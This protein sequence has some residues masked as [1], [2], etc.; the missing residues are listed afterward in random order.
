MYSVT[1]YVN[2]FLKFRESEAIE[3]PGFNIDANQKGVVEEKKK[4]N[5][6]PAL[7]LGNVGLV[8]SL[9][10]AGIPVYVGSEARKNPCFY[11]RYVKGKVQFSTYR[12]QTFID[13]LCEFGKTLDQKAVIFSDD[14]DALLT[15]SNHRDQLS[16]YF[17]FLFPPKETV[18]KVLDKQEFS[19]LSKIH[20]LPAPASFNI[21]SFDE[22]KKSAKQCTFP[23]IIKPVFRSDWYREDFEKIVG[24]YKKAYK[25]LDEEE[26]F[27]MYKKVS[28]I[29]KKVVLQEYIEGDDTYHY[30]V[31]M[32]V[33]KDEEVR[34]YYIAKKLRIYPIGAGMG[35]F[36][37][38]V[39]DEVV[40][41][42]AVEVVKALNLRGLLNIQF[43]RDSRTGEPKLIEIHFR[44]S[45]WG[46]IGV[47]AD[48][49]LYN[50][51]YQGL[52]GEELCACEDYKDG[53][54]YVNLN[55]DIASFLQYKAAGELTFLKWISSYRGKLVLGDFKASDP[56]PYFMIWWLAT[57]AQIKLKLS[58]R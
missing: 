15:I 12:N 11:S 14:D 16:E 28:R 6:Y 39:K 2:L 1:D 10:K 7:V 40:Y 41:K 49:N 35:S 34:G 4:A 32:Y 25:C 21:T 23:C 17:H 58:L 54:K 31:N 56:I 45:I 9:S 22:L 8:Y 36:I 46:Y 3:Y 55:R 57:L 50:F 26:L 44:N 13:E 5:L 18:N 42:K 24:S 27:S 51:Y 52:T 38:T 33:D 20:E 47:A 37:S 43:K 29:N 19:K 48:I 53:V 30:S